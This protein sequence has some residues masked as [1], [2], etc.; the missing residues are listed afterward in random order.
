[1]GG[2]HGEGCVRTRCLDD[3]RAAMG[4]RREPERRAGRAHELELPRC[5]GRRLGVTYRRLDFWGSALETTSPSSDSTDP[6]TFLGYASIRLST[7]LGQ[8]AS[9]PST[10]LTRVPKYP[11]IAQ[12]RCH[13]PGA[14][15]ANGTTSNARALLECSRDCLADVHVPAF[16]SLYE[17]CSSS[18]SPSAIFRTTSLTQ[19][20]CRHPRPTAYTRQQLVQFQDV[21]TLSVISAQLDARD[22]TPGTSLRHPA[23]GKRP[24]MRDIPSARQDSTSHPPLPSTP[25]EPMNQKH[26]PTYWTHVVLFSYASPDASKT[27]D[28][29][30][31]RRTGSWRLSRVGKSGE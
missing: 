28:S 16:S 11:T 30:G 4:Y 1:M 20:L 29:S 15:F 22:S 7:L 23:P 19:E 14:D 17:S 10:F 3:G 27:S 6:S 21:P 2:R 8:T 9:I 31:K 24:I 26:T 13:S 18:M 5:R 12:A 25:P